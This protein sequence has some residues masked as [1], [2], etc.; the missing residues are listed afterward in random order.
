MKHIVYNHTQQAFSLNFLA[1]EDY[2]LRHLHNDET[3]LHLFKHTGLNIGIDDLKLIHEESSLPIDNIFLRQC[4]G[5]AVYTDEGVVNITL[6]YKSDDNLHKVYHQFV[7]FITDALKP[8]ALK[9]ES[10]TIEHSYCSGLYDLSVNQKKFCG[11]AQRKVKDTVSLHAYI[12]VEGDQTPR[13]QAVQQFYQNLNAKNTPFLNNDVMCSLNQVT[14]HT[15][16]T[17]SVTQLI[18]DAFSQTP[19]NQ[20]ID[21]LDLE[22][23]LQRVIKQ[24]MR[25]GELTQK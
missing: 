8:L 14:K 6:L 11:I 25:L 3:V 19:L 23:S 20:S 4:G 18:I 2:Y 9:I 7:D 5:K 17:E 1:L 22:N 12:A 10:G 21:N 16:T 13:T 24:Q 15:C